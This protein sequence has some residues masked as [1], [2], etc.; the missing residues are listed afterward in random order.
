MKKNYVVDAWI[1]ETVSS[2]KKVED[3]N[4][5]KKQNA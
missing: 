4:L 5:G 3:K 2:K 1:E